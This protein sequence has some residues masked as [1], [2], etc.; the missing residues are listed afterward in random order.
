MI[1]VKCIAVN[2]SRHSVMHSALRLVVFLLS[3]GVSLASRRTSHPLGLDQDIL[4][5]ANQ[6]WQELAA[7]K[8]HNI[9]SKIPSAWELPQSVLDEAKSQRKLTG[10]FIESLLDEQT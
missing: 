5:S 8:R 2:R 7:Q 1:S 10:E 4:S 9:T 6:P 3:F